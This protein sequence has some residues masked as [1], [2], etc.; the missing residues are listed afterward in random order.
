MLK[1][2]YSNKTNKYLYNVTKA[3][4]LT[5]QVL[6]LKTNILQ[7]YLPKSVLIVGNFKLLFQT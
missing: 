5:I 2:N 6:L 1:R 3:P 4:Y 7:T